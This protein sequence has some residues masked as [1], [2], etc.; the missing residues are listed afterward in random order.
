MGFKNLL[1]S[2]YMVT[3]DNIDAP[4]WGAPMIW[5][6]MMGAEENFDLWPILDTSEIG[7]ETPTIE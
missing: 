4:R 2:T 7:I 3:N 5:G 1:I 6:D